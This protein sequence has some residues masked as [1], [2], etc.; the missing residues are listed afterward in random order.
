MHWPALTMFA[1]LL[2]ITMESEFV[3][4]EPE[5]VA[6]PLTALPPEV[7]PTKLKESA[8]AELGA[9]AMKIIAATDV[10]S[11]LS[12]EDMLFIVWLFWLT[13]NPLHDYWRVLGGPA[14]RPAGPVRCP[15]NR[16][17]ASSGPK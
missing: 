9:A 3:P 10:K 6:V 11:S 17:R 12:V 1:W 15:A 8:R 5:K 13:P 16:L 14:G 4:G 2:V 7:V